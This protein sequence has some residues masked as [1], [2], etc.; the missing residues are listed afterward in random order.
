MASIEKNAF[1]S[2][3]VTPYELLFLCFPES[4][5][6]RSFSYAICKPSLSLT[7]NEV[8]QPE[9]L[10][11]KSLQK[12]RAFFSLL[13]DRGSDIIPDL[14]WRQIL[15]LKETRKE[16]EGRDEKRQFEIGSREKKVDAFKCQKIL[17]RAIVQENSRKE[18]DTN[19]T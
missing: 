11:Q 1:D 6:K 14:F 5:Q 19:I 13:D 3:W 9:S 2:L 18:P 12:T 8:G 4:A 10:L 7:R 16:E 15:L 17:R